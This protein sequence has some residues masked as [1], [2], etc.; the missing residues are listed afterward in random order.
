MIPRKCLS[1]YTPS[2]GYKYYPPYCN[3]SIEGEQVIVT[4]RASEE[5]NDCG[6]TVSMEIPKEI[7]QEMLS[8]TVAGLTGETSEL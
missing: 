1:A 2:T 7:F 5:G 8:K 6:K 4:V 3:I